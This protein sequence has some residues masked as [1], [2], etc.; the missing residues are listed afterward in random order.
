MSC[1]LQEPVDKQQQHLDLLSQR[2]RRALEM[3]GNPVFLDGL[4]FGSLMGQ[5]K[6][7]QIHML[8]MLEH[9]D[10]IMINLFYIKSGIRH[11]RMSRMQRLNIL[12]LWGIFQ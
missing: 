5:V 4:S 6:S 7:V 10:K 11:L 8:K 2:G 12:K 1:N 3:R 9:F